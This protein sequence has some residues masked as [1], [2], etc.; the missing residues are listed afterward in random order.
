MH[1][2]G[3]YMILKQKK[4]YAVFL[5]TNANYVYSLFCMPVMNSV[6]PLSGANIKNHLQNGDE[7]RVVKKDLFYV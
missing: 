3:F 6:T 2:L 5:P 4:T 1:G 7:P